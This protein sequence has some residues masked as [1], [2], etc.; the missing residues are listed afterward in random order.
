[1]VVV[2]AELEFLA[3]PSKCYAVVAAVVG[4]LALSLVF[5]HLRSSIIDS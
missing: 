2:V 5:G 4:R 3:E 1:M